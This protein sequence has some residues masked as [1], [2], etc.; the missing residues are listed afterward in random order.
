MAGLQQEAL[1]LPSGE[2]FQVL[3]DVIL[4]QALMQ[5]TPAAPGLSANTCTDPGVKDG[6]LVALRQVLSDRL[7]TRGVDGTKFLSGYPP[8]CS[9]KQLVYLVNMA[10]FVAKK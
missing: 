7:K 8:E 10:G 1:R 2:L 5:Q 6:D 9:R 4:P 3:G